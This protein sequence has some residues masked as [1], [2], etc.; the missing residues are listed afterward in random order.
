VRQ[1][2]RQRILATAE[3]LLLSRGFQGFSY[4]HIAERLDI[5]TAAVHYHFPTKADLGLALLQRYRERFRWWAWQLREQKV[6]PVGCLEHFITLERRLVEAN[7]VCPLSV[8]CVELQGVSDE[9]S[10][11]AQRL[12]DDALHWLE[13]VLESGREANLFHFDGSAA[14][15]ALV[16]LVT[17]QG[18][19]QLA[20]L[21]G[22]ETF[23]AVRAQIR[24]DLG[25]PAIAPTGRVAS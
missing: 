17:L 2:T 14:A 7:R 23:D 18:A 8:V 20:R 25:L 10:A 16:V 3:E 5:R 24:Q 22:I 1:D 4:H 19:L 13:I 21:N 12:L 15:R 11:A 6:S 9:M